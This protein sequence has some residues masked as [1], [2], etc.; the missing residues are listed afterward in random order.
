[1]KGAKGKGGSCALGSRHGSSSL[2][3]AA[4]SDRFS[5]RLPLRAF[6]LVCLILLPWSF[7]YAAT[8]TY[9]AAGRLK[10]AASSTGQ[11]A[12][13]TYD[14]LGHL[15]AIESTSSAQLAIQSFAPNVGEMGANVSINGSGFATSTSGNAVAFSGTAAVVLT[16]ASNQL[17][18]Q[19]PQGAISG[20]ISVTVG[21]ATVVSDGS[22]T[23]ATIGPPT[24]TTVSPSIS[25]IGATV[26]LNGQSLDPIAGETTLT[27]DGM[28]VPISSIS[29]TSIVFTV[30]AWAG[31]GPIV[32]ATPYGIATAGPFLVVPLG[33]DP[34]TVTYD[35]PLTEGGPAEAVSLSGAAPIGAY[36]F[37]GFVGDWVSLQAS[38]FSDPNATASYTVYSPTGTAI[39]SGSISASN[40]SV[41]LPQ[42]L[43]HG[44]YSIFFGGGSSAPQ[45][46]VALEVDT[47]L[48]L[49]IP[50]TVSTSTPGRGERLI[51]YAAQ[52]D[53]LGIGISNIN[54]S[55]LCITIYNP[56][57][58]VAWGTQCQSGPYGTTITSDITIRLANVQIA[59]TYTIVLSAPTNFSAQ[60]VVTHDLVG[61]LP[62]NAT[63]TTFSLVQVGQ[64]GWLDF[65][66]TAGQNIALQVS[67]L[68]EPMYLTIYN[69]D[70]TVTLLN[71]G[72]GV[73]STSQTSTFNFTLPQTGTYK[74]FVQP[75]SG[76][77]GSLTATLAV[78]AAPAPITVGNGTSTTV[79]NNVIPGQ[80]TYATFTANQ[81]DSLGIG[82]SSIT[83]SYLCITI[84]NPNGAV[85]WGTQC[86]SGPYGTTITSDIAIRLANIQI[87]GT[88]T[89]VLS[90]STNFSAQLVVTPDLI[91]TLP[92][93]ATPMTFSLGEVGQDGWLDFN[94]TA[95]QNI[96]LQVS[97]LSEPMYLT[98][99]N[100]DGTVTLLNQGPGVASTS[101]TSTFNFTLPQTGTYKIFVQPV[102]GAPGSL[103][104]T[105]AIDAAPVQ[106]LDDSG[107]SQPISNTLGGQ[108]A[109]ATFTANVGDNLGIGFG[110]LIGTN[111]LCLTIY[112]PTAQVF[113]GNTCFYNTDGIHFSNIQIPGTYTVVLA[114]SGAGTTFSVDMAV[115]HDLVESLP[116]DGTPTTMSLGDLGQDG[117]L[118]FNG[119]VG[120]KIALQISSL[121]A[122]LYLTIYNPD[123]T[124][125]L[126]N[127]GPSVGG[128]SQS[129]IFNLT[130]PE[131]GTYEILVQPENGSTDS[132]TISATATAST[133]SSQ[134]VDLI[135]HSAAPSGSPSLSASQYKFGSPSS[136]D[137]DPNFANVE[138]LMHFEQPGVTASSGSFN[139]TNPDYVTVANSSDFDVGSGDFTWEAWVYPTSVSGYQGIFSKR[140][141]GNIYAPF[142]FMLSGGGMW[143]LM[144]ADGS[145]WTVNVS[146]GSGMSA[147]V[148]HHVMVSRVAGTL[149]LGFDGTI[150]ASASANFTVTQNSAPISIG[151]TAANGYAPFGGYI[152]EVR[153]TKGV[154]RYSGSSYTVPTSA[155]PNTGPGQPN[156]SWNPNDCASNI[157]LSNSS[158]DAAQ[159]GSGSG[160]WT[161]C[162]SSSAH[163]TGKFYAECRD[164][165]DGPLNGS[166]LFGVATSAM[167]LSSYVGSD[168][169]SWSIQPNNVSNLSTYHGGSQTGGL[170]SGL[171]AGGYTMVAVDLDAGNIWFGINGAWVSG[172]N[173]AAGTNPAYT[174]VPN[175]P[176]Y[177]ALAELSFPQE[178]LLPAH[179]M[180]SVPSGFSPWN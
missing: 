36:L 162:R 32:V 104:A 35:P 26:T 73:A 60:L 24:I 124:V 61:T 69:P 55:Y 100:P 9:D 67:N 112:G 41:H 20:P 119:A 176:L 88:Y 128:T 171:G 137:S 38:G 15:I 80:N 167:S 141:N 2:Y 22:F 145:N 76:A 28:D 95:G 47:S 93:N 92:T 172:G 48:T 158:L 57:G 86:Q 84:Y 44:A 136:T 166:L 54:V 62:A 13:Y 133:P 180:G 3:Y 43:S 34:S 17:L 10:T 169:N 116:T 71:Q 18:V 53:N 77:P 105:L 157:S 59:G 170:G 81:G 85:V 30:P 113:L 23:I 109:Y 177:L 117:L 68:S 58:A 33:V 65:N 151:A 78:D 56:N 27:L 127:Q 179:F 134:F 12:T 146:G 153:F 159:G 83:A 39:S 50:L 140:A 121:T 21:G 70:G 66:G 79:S 75:V 5:A 51:S 160:T 46:S 156:A 178:C 64:D 96:A 99:Y 125:T 31:S 123:G 4:G 25:D 101:Q 89:I 174:F 132:I 103:T 111:Y 135:G 150:V 72:P 97:N 87:A 115:T 138:L 129:T 45:F 107:N 130:L 1:M 7:A 63:P 14:S 144:S 149:Y 11:S 131:N 142:D 147:N 49:N 148:W 120:E 102:S 161:A 94:G 16:A 8:Y 139:S 106:V 143:A 108:E 163:S 168:A 91:E 114:P 122:P 40:P 74:I 37:Q 90:A 82:I 110:N 42:L 118:D 152:D 173:P 175:T 19:V 52:G 126:L 155:F 6:L 154:G 164:V 98:I 29:N 165:V